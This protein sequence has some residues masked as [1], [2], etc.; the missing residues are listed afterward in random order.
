[1]VILQEPNEELMDM[2]MCGNNDYEYDPDSG[3]IENN[4]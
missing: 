3:C 4:Q 1:M 2:S